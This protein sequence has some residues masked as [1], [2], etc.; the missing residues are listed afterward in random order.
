[1]SQAD[2]TSSKP[3]ATGY[4]KGASA[5]QISAPAKVTS[6]KSAV[7]SPK[8]TRQKSLI[9]QLNDTSSL[10]LLFGGLV[11]LIGTVGIAKLYRKSK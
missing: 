4:E 9:P 6:S 7:Q 3:V 5:D 1:M 10:S 2:N 11:L 8:S